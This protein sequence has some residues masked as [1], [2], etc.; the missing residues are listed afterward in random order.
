MKAIALIEA[1]DHVCYRY[2]IEPF[3]AD[4]AERGLQLDAVPLVRNTLRR[5]RQLR[6]VRQADLVILQRKRLPIWQIVLL[7][8]A[9]RRLVYDFDDALFQRDSFCGKKPRSWRHLSRFWATLHAADAVIA[10]NA[11]LKQAA[12]RF[13][14]PERIHVVPTC[15]EPAKY[16]LAVHR[17]V[18]PAVKLVWI[19]QRST[20]PSLECAGEHLAA[21]AERLPGVEL[22][23]IADCLL[24]LAGVKAVPR[25]WSSATEAAELADADIGIT[26]FPNDRWSR[27]KCGL[28]LLQYMAA[29]LPVV[30][31]SVGVHAEM[32]IHGQTGFLASTPHEWAE[33]I[34]RLA[35]DPDLRCRM[36]AAGRLRVEEHYSVGAWGPRWAELISRLA[37][38]PATKTSSHAA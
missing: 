31:N 5:T 9:A 18:G 22:R 25:P 36:G 2:R 12:S 1:P 11:Y 32:V 24:P 10:G 29:G 17:R 28:K 7:R 30:A 27:G 26:W 8:R 33:A 3:L 13:V 20:F 16:T 15:V 35:S 34:H 21:A 19:G 37:R 23:V 14:E 4:L 6:A 38:S